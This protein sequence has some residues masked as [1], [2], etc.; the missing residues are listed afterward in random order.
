MFIFHEKGSF[1]KVPEF[2]SFIFF[3]K[4]ILI[5]IL[6]SALKLN[7][8]TAQYYRIITCPLPTYIWLFISSAHGNIELT[9]VNWLY[10]FE[11]NRNILISPDYSVNIKISSQ[12][13]C[14]IYNWRIILCTICYTDMSSVFV[15]STKNCSLLFP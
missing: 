11:S 15:L 3:I 7:N 4:E 6:L 9:V 13:Q 1:K 5:S 12:L 10:K 2:I 14:L 8:Y